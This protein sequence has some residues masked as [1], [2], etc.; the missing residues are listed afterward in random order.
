[1]DAWRSKLIRV[2]FTGHG[3]EG[4]T[5]MTSQANACE[6]D[7][8]CQIAQRL[9]LSC[10]FVG[11]HRQRHQVSCGRR[12]HRPTV[13][14]TER[15]T[16]DALS[17]QALLRATRLDTARY[18]GA[19]VHAD[20]SANS[21]SVDHRPPIF[22]FLPD[23]FCHRRRQE[24]NEPSFAASESCHLFLQICAEVTSSSLAGPSLAFRT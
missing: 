19:S 23:V 10:P 12:P 16:V 15:Q 2:T 8:H 21:M 20:S 18:P 11:G 4:F 7:Q 24:E 1:M 17:E 13:I 6:S 5:T 22:N 9:Q 14:K 3:G